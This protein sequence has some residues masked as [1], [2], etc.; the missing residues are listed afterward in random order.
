MDIDKDGIVETKVR[1]TS[2]VKHEL[3]ELWEVDVPT[4]PDFVRNVDNLFRS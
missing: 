4:L 1:L 2:P 3:T